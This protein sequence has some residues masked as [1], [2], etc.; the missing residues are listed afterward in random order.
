MGSSAV[1]LLGKLG[2]AP[3]A[4]R[5]AG[6]GAKAGTWVAGERPKGCLPTRFWDCKFWTAKR[7]ERRQVRRPSKDEALGR[8]L[9]LGRGFGNRLGFLLRVD[10]GSVLLPHLGATRTMMEREGLLLASGP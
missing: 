10:L 5:R 9:D 2:P 8:V 7:I 1:R 6:A 3:A 4:C